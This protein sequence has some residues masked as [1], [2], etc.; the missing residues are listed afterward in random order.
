M[1]QIPMSEADLLAA[2]LSTAE[3]FGWL[4]HHDRPAR[5]EKG[6][7]TAVEG[8]AGFPDLVLAR[9]SVVLFIELKS[10]TGRVSVTQ[11][12]WLDALGAQ[13]WRPDQWRDGTILR[14][15]S[16]WDR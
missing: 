16:N 13:V 1:T 6:W 2:V 10:A 4:A 12:R 8:D 9:D 5:T 7:R 11:Q 14:A 3:R 15:L